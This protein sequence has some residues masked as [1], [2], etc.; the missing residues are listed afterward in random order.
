MYTLVVG[1][2]GLVGN[3]IMERFSSEGLRVTGTYHTSPGEN[4]TVQLSKTDKRAVSRLISKENP[5]LI[6]DAAA[7]HDVDECEKQRDKAW[8]VNATGTRNLAVAAAEEN[9]QFVYISTDYIFPGTPEHTPYTE[10]DLVRPINYYGAC[11]YA[12]EQ[13]AKIADQSTIL[14]SSVLYGLSN[15]NFLT[16]IFRNLHGSQ[17]IE[18]VND[19]IGT[20]TYAADIAEACLR[21]GQQN[22]T[23]LFHAGGPESISRYEFARILVETCDFDSKEVNPMTSEELKQRADR[24]NDSSLDST[25]LYETIDYQFR[26]PATAFENMFEGCDRLTIEKIVSSVL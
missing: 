8:T 26:S 25:E 20:P 24:P 22:E 2:S 11:K 21:I 7:F 9:S 3:Y 15:R 19:Q 10:N 6:I 16:W 14:R 5:D 13:A 12:G 17:S 4:A 18:V 1:A 23:G